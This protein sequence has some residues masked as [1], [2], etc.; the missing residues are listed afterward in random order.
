MHGLGIRIIGSELNNKR[1][2]LIKLLEF[3][4][5]TGFDSIELTPE[6]FDAI[7][8]GELER[9]NADSLKKV[10]SSFHF[11]ISV[12]VPLLLNLFNREY[13]ALHLLVLEKTLEFA[14]II[15][16]DLLVYHPGRYV[17]SSEFARFGRENLSVE[18]KRRL[19]D[20]EINSVRILA[21]KYQHITIA[22][23]NL[24]SYLDHSP[25]SYAEYP[26]ELADQVRSVERKNVGVMIDT[27]HLLIAS[28]CLGFDP[29]ESVIASGIEPVHFHINDNH[30]IPT[31]YTEKDKKGQLPFGRGDE[32]LVP[33]LG[34]FPFTEFLKNFRS[35]SGR[36]VI[37]LTNRYFNGPNIADS[38]ESLRKILKNVRK[39]GEEP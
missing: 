22:F 24:R 7:M 23:E 37:E 35:Y 32:H 12:H 39:R 9:K 5:K 14:S 6:D 17:D 30:G 16:A 31:Y 26:R 19:K 36:Y 21:D 11:R 33:G 2:E 38:C 25:Y 8:T 28:N 34:R 15:G 10:L 3:I 27:G 18:E 13:P 4:E 20:G 29:V 1:E